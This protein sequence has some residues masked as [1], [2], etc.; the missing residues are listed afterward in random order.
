MENFLKLLGV[1]FAN[2]G[3]SP[4]ALLANVV[5]VFVA[6]CLYLIVM[7]FPAL[8]QWGQSLSTTSV[9]REI[10]AQREDKFPAVAREKAMALFLQTQADAVF[11]MK[12]EP[13]AVNDYQRVLVW[14]GKMPLEK[15][16][17]EP[18]PVDKSSELYSTQLAGENLAVRWDMESEYF[19]GRNIPTF[20]NQNF[21]FVYTCPF[22]NL[23]NIYSGYIG[24]A[25]NELPMKVEDKQSLLNY[26]EYLGKI[27]NSASRYLG[28]SI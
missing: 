4:G 17:Y 28:R 22:F 1:I 13:E 24:I 9:L 19:K 21:D 10:Q 26:E 12:Y 27:C 11:V 23:N 3:K 5:S 25:W 14:E 15:I 6:V 2:F 7:H 18:K 20:R 8:I 16:D